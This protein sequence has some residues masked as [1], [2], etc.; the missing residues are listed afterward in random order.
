[1][2]RLTAKKQIT[3]KHISAILTI[4]LKES[5]PDLVFLM[6]NFE[7]LDVSAGELLNLQLHLEYLNLIKDGVITTFGDN[8]VETEMVYI[9]ESGFYDLYYIAQPELGLD[10][11]IIHFERKS[12][13]MDNMDGDTK[14]FSEYEQFDGKKWISWKDKELEFGV[15]FERSGDNLPMIILKKEID[16]V[17]TLDSKDYPSMQNTMR[18]NGNEFKYEDKSY[19]NFDLNENLPNLVSD[20]DSQMNAKRVSFKNIKDNSDLLRK[21]KTREHG[22]AKQLIFADGKDDDT[23]FID[24]DHIDIVP[25]TNRDAEIWIGALLRLYLQ[26]EK[27]HATLE[28]CEDIVRNLIDDSPLNRSHPTLSLKGNQIFKT[29]KGFDDNDIIQDIQTAEDLSPDNS[30]LIDNSKTGGFA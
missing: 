19:T 2:V 11:E 25:K 9:P 21:F 26:E 20:W 8:A 12:P 6:K 14:P 23:W 4:K 7:Q 3:I 27:C 13:N 1:M 16:C 15:Y 5:R 24:I 10:A 30:F 22:L 18:M 29:M 17:V 28:Y